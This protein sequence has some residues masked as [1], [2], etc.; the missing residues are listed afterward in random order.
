MGD[1]P[2]PPLPRGW[3]L[4]RDYDGKVYF[5]DHNTKQTTWVDP[6]SDR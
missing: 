6:R 4:G 5:I 3:D 1:L 2:C